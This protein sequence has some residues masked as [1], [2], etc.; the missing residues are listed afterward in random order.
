MRRV[1]V[2]QGP[3][4]SRTQQQGN[5]A[6]GKHHR[7]Q[8]HQLERSG[9]ELHQID[10]GNARVVHLTEELPEVGAPLMPYPCLGEEAR[11]AAGFHDAIRKVDVFAEAHLREAAKLFVDIAADAH[12]ERTGEKLVELL[13]STTDAAGGEEGG[14]R[15]A[16]GFLHRRER[17]VGAVGAA[18]GI[19]RLSV[20]LARYLFY[21]RAREDNVRVEHNK[22]IAASPFSTVV[23]ALSGPAVRLGEILHV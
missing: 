23:T 19:G 5:D 12:V 3:T 7:Q 15:I 2:H 21:I 17:L 13:L 1:V 22:I 11:R 8:V 9:V 20:E 10:T 6:D 18:K 4:D 16:D 14:H